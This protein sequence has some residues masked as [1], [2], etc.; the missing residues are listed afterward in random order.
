MIAATMSASG[1]RSALMSS[2]A[3]SSALS[4][5]CPPNYPIAQVM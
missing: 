3:I 4:A 1:S 5:T 2:F